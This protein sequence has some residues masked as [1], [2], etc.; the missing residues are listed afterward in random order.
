MR[1][2]RIAVA[3]GKGGTGKTT[4]AANLAV[5]AGQAVELLDCDVEEPNVHIFLSG[6]VEE[7]QE[8]LITVPQIDESRCNGCGECSDFCQYNAIVSAVDVPFIFPEMCHGC[9]GCVRICPQSAMF[10]TNRRVGVVER[11]NVK[12]HPALSLIQGRLDIG[13]VMAPAVVKG[14]REMSLGNAVTIIDSAPGASCPVIAALSDVDYV[15]LV[16]EPT[17]FGLND[18]SLAVEMVRMLKVPFGAVINRCDAGD[19]RVKSY[20]EQE[21]IEILLEIPDERKIAVAYSK[22]SLMSQAFPEYRDK[23]SS[24]FSR[25]V[26]RI[27]REKRKAI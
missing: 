14:V 26:D 3:S 4:V 25:I 19:N 15:V 27:N 1:N 16:T 24:T 23:F 8:V 18:F 5:S 10:E 13:A 22:G 9:G 11:L 6:D 21:G 20:C 7:S 2:L 12:G 17:P